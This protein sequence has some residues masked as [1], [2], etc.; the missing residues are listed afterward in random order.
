MLEMGSGP[1]SGRLSTFAGKRPQLIDDGLHGVGRFGIL[2]PTQRREA[3]ME[4]QERL[5]ALDAVRVF[6]PS[7]NTMTH[8]NDSTLASLTQAHKKY[9]DVLALNGIDLEIRR[10]ELLAVLGP[11]GAGKSTAISLLLGLQQPS[12]GAVHLFGKSP[13]DLDAR[14]NTG[15]MMQEVTLAPELKVREHIDLVAS[16]YPAPYS[17]EEAMAMTRITDLG[18]RPYRKLS[19]GQKRQVQFAMAICGRPKLLFLDEP[20]VGLDVHA[21]EAM[22]ATIRK[23]VADGCS[24]VLTT[25][26]LEEAESLADR[27]VVVNKGRV[28]ASGTVADLR[29]LVSRRQLSCI[30]RLP[31][32]H[33]RTWS[34]VE[35]ITESNGRISITTSHAEIV[36]RRLLSEDEHVSELEIRRAGLAEA[37]S[38]LTKDAA[39]ETA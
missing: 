6:A 3:P 1:N 25:H 38:T 35:A 2:S 19:G 30:T 18:E 22:W 20:T 33:V 8:T 23:L 13:N 32:E 11:N 7:E 29:S 24:I 10:G 5:H 17:A 36:A 28:I 34:E 21:R 14:R 39:V 27:V 16:Y 4:Q 15:V 37:F 12:S 31:I 26:Y 9:G